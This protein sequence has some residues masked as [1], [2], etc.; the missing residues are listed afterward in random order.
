MNEIDFEFRYGT[1]SGVSND[2]ITLCS[3][4]SLEKLS[5][6]FALAQCVK[7][8]IYEERIWNEMEENKDIP[9]TLARTGTY[10]LHGY[11]WQ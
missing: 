4:S 9:L 3:R 6:S 11:P 5:V 1:T 2:L 8:S 10:S 7:L